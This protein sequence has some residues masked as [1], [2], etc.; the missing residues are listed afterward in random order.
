MKKT[1]FKKSLSV[2][3]AVLMI[4]SCWVFVPGEHNHAQ[5]IEY[6][7]NDVN[8]VT[9]YVT[10]D[11]VI[12]T[13][14][15]SSTAEELDYMK[16]GSIVSD[17]TYAGEFHTNVSVSDKTLSS[18]TCVD[19]GATLS[20]QSLS[21]WNATTNSFATETVLTGDL[22]GGYG[23]NTMDTKDSTATLKFTFSDG[24]YELRTLYVKTNP[25]AQH[26]LAYSLGYK[27]GGNNVRVAS[28]E[29]VAM[30]SYG[31][32]ANGGFHTSGAKYSGQ[33]NFR[34]IYAPRDTTYCCQN[35]GGINGLLDTKNYDI[36]KLAGYYVTVDKRDN[37]PYAKLF[38]A[39]ANYYLDISSDV[40][41]GIVKN[42]DG[43]YSFKMLYGNLYNSKEK[44]AKPIQYHEN[45][46]VP[47]FYTNDTTYDSDDQSVSAYNGMTVSNSVDMT[48]EGAFNVAKTVVGYSTITFSATSAG[49]IS[50]KYQANCQHTSGNSAAARVYIPFNITVVDKSALRNVYNKYVGEKLQAKYYTSK[51]WNKYSNA[52]IEADYYLNNYE[53]STANEAT[54]KANLEAAYKALVPNTYDISYENLFSFS[55]WAKTDCRNGNEL[56]TVTV[57]EQAGTVTL[58]G[59]GDFYTEYGGSAASFYTVPVTEG[60]E[61]TFSYNV[62]STDG[63]QAFVFFYDDDGNDVTGATYN[64]VAQ[65]TPHIGVYNGSPITFTVPTGCTRV[66]VRF[67][68]TGTGKATFSNIAIYE[69]TRAEEVGLL[70]WTNREYRKVFYYN[71]ILTTNYVPAR[72]G[73]AFKNWYTDNGGLQ[74][75]FTNGS[76]KAVKSHTLYSTWYDYPLDV[77]YENLFSLSEWANVADSKMNNGEWSVD[78]NTGELTF[79]QTGSS[80]DNNVNSWDY[81][82]PVTAG[83]TY[84]FE[85][86]CTVESG[87]GVQIHLFLNASTDVKD[88][89]IGFPNTGSTQNVTTLTSAPYFNSTK[90]GNKI[91]FVV[92]D[93]ATNLNV[94][95]GTCYEKG[96]TNTISNIR[97]YETSR[98]DLLGKLSDLKVRDIISDSLTLNKPTRVGYSFQGWFTEP[99]GKGTKI[100]DDTAKT[101]TASTSVYS[102]WTANTYSITYKANGGTGNDE[103]VSSIHCDSDHTLKGANIFSRTGYTF[104]E[105]NTKADGTGVAYA[106]GGNINICTDTDITLYAQWTINQYTVKF[107]KADGTTAS[108]TKYNYGTKASDIKAPANT[109]NTS[110]NALQHY[111]YSWPEVKD[112]GAA[113]VTYEEIGT[114]KNHT[115]KYKDL[116]DTQHTEYCIGCNYTSNKDHSGGSATC[117]EQATCQYCNTKYGT[118]LGH[119]FTSGTFKK[120]TDGEN[121]THQQKCK[122]CDTY[123]NEAKHTWSDGVIEPDSTCTSTGTKTYTC[124]A[125]GCKA[126][127]TKTLDLAAHKL[128][129]TEAKDAKCEEAGN[130]EYWTCSVCGK[131]FSDANGTTEIKL[132]DIV[133]AQLGHN[134]TGAVK[135]N[136]NGEKATHSYLC[137]NGCGTYGGAIAHTWGAGVVKPAATCTTDGTETFTCTVEGCKA[138]YTKT[139]PATGHSFT[140]ENAT[141]D[142]LATK[143]TCRDAATYYKSCTACGLTSKDVTGQEATFKSGNA[144]GHSFAQANGVKSNSNDTHSFKCVRCDTYG[145]DT[146]VGGSEKC[147]GGTANCVD[148]AVCTVCSAAYGEVDSTKHKTVVKDAAVAAKCEATGLTEGSHCSA[149]DTV[150]VAQTEIPATGH[151]FDGACVKVGDSSHAYKCTNKNCNTTGVAG[152]AGSTEACYGEGMTNVTQIANDETY[153]KVTCKCGNSKEV[154]H[155][156]GDWKKETESSTEKNGTM[157]NTCSVCG[158][159]KTSNCDYVVVEGSYQAPTCTEDGHQ[160]WICKDCGN[161]YSQVL[162]ATGEHKYTNYVSNNDATCTADGT[163]TA[164]CDMCKTAGDTVTDEGSKLGH[165]YDETKSETNLTRPVYDEETGTWADGY[166]TYTCKNNAAHTKT[167]PAKRADYTDYDKAIS[168]LEKLLDQDLSDEAKEN[169]EKALEEANK[170][171]DNLIDSEQDDV[172]K[173]VEEIN[174]A[175]KDNTGNLK[176][177]TVTFV[178]GDGKTIKTEPVISGNGATAPITATKSSDATNHYTFSGWDESF[179]NVTSD[180][181]VKATFTSAE[182]NFTTHTD[183]D[184]NVHT[185]KCDC[186]YTV[187][188]SHGYN[189]GVITTPA[190]CEEKGVKTYTCSICQG[191]KTEKIDALGHKNKEHHEA[192]PATCIATGTIEY[193][194]CPDCSTNYSDEACTT[195]VT[196]LTAAINPNNHKNTEEKAQQ[197]ATCTA[198]GYEAGVYCNDCKTW[199]SGHEK[200]DALGHNLSKTDAKAATCKDTGNQAYWTCSVCGDV[201]SDENGT[202]KTTVADMTLG[203]DANNHVGETEVR[204][205]K[206]A[207]CHEKG[208]TGDTYCLSCGNV[209]ANGT[210]TEIDKTNHVGGTK[211]E[212]EDTVPGTCKKAETW[213]EVTYCLGCNDVLKTEPKTGEINKDNHEDTTEVRGYKAADCGNNGYTGDTYYKCCDALVSKGE[214]IPATGEHKYGF[215]SHS[216]PTCTGSGLHVET[217]TVCG[218]VKKTTIDPAG[219]D[220]SKTSVAATCKVQAH[221]HYQ[222]KNCDYNYDD[223]FNG[224][225][226]P[227]SWFE[228]DPGKEPTCT[229]TGLTAHEECL[230]CG[231]EKKATTIPMLG[232]SDKDGDGV[233]DNCDGTMLNG[234]H[235]CGCICHKDSFI[236]RIIYAIARFFWKI[237]KINKTCSCGRVHY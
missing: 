86:D 149:C 80:Q 189:D 28:I 225:L 118:A 48:E 30:G 213:N 72:P 78:I 36:E 40:N 58:D 174:K 196:D 34:K 173:A 163:K 181:T 85:F 205:T 130:I 128:T 37:A 8:Q 70:K 29:V 207:N 142:Y 124:K 38:T 134:Y 93:N 9:G 233:C 193:W 101:L 184:D 52:L 103:T 10:V 84:T 183:K 234:S 113:D 81:D 144:L 230:V 203:I 76:N 120:V 201:F 217:C 87:S 198:D 99:D 62:T 223:G 200:I 165:D 216:E 23:Y 160:T 161:G 71:D 153:H 115:I 41:S 179:T 132:A 232:H 211:V 4:M 104:K 42:N 139:V 117:T 11:P 180:L 22:G 152:R 154:A 171:P 66:G 94:R 1:Y 56:G 7:T 49:N 126:T 31:Q 2:I 110:S 107:V 131:Y 187:D 16:Y 148:K 90:T 44:D 111:V 167:E 172:N 199:V 190:K 206:T 209:K 15:D 122:N 140:K 204:G 26:G 145:T 91:T 162:K 168:D 95:F 5:A 45:W 182:H 69:T 137:K 92:P 222:C 175:I 195:A 106:A 235:A 108:E 227:H 75:E 53:V 191:T 77:N 178:D 194:S 116:T 226:A 105:W 39:T 219:H 228:L 188:V 67:G 138:T 166:Y 141:D 100:T 215:T 236:M 176:E 150:I 224:P 119:D 151:K 135:S 143:A 192:V 158:Y 123:G 18:I 88:S 63:M 156:W 127:Y 136:G 164:V 157:S 231:D 208:Y 74:L 54:L 125:D 21:V 159:K 177:Y 229:E 27:T 96:V 79:K 202:T 32:A 237:F 65:T 60:T 17:G 218:D 20:A 155:T 109:A 68:L 12:Y 83:K 170:L 35:S 210:E 133:I 112:L 33:F 129:K 197:D 57:D 64:G 43:T 24:T 61:Y 47:G 212:K 89:W 186:G 25:V 98:S 102:K 3:M 169:I 19:T 185:D 82:I 220:C 114:L 59:S 73:Y 50:G 214:V 13:H 14:G 146:T 147:S 97:L 221:D 46:G 121:G 55:E 6:G 51:S